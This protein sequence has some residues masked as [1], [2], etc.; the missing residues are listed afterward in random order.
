[1]RIFV[2]SIDFLYFLC[3]NNFIHI[4]ELFYSGGFN[5][6]KHRNRK[7]VTFA[8]AAKTKPWVVGLIPALS[9]RHLFSNEKTP[10]TNSKIHK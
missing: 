3:Y 1:M 6:M 8:E 7:K 10:K 9:S 2:L 4:N 5:F